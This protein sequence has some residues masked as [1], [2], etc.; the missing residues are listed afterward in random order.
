M[1]IGFDNCSIKI[2]DLNGSKT[3][4]IDQA[5]D[6]WA[7]YLFQL[8]NG[9]LASPGNYKR[10]ITIKLGKLADLSLLQSIELGHKNSISSIDVWTGLGVEQILPYHPKNF[11]ELRILKPRKK[12]SKRGSRLILDHFRSVT[13]ELCQKSL[14]A[15]SQ[16]FNS[17]P[18]MNDHS[19]QL[20]CLLSPFDLI[21]SNVM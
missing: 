13:Y 4:A 14:S 18:I 1:T 15:G 11:I 16:S 10:E 17:S 8:S 9:N 20:P 2:F 7:I 21:L 12:S 6:L 3:R 19:S 5:H